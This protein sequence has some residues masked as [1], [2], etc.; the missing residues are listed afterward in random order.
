MFKTT[1]SVL[2]FATAVAGAQTVTVGSTTST[3]NGATTTITVPVMVAVPPATGT[4]GTSSMASLRVEAGASLGGAIT[5]ALGSADGFKTVAL[6]KVVTDTA[7][8]WNAATNS[9]TVPATGTY[10]IVSNIRLADFAPSGISY[11][12]GVDTANVDSFSFLWTSTAAGPRNGF[13][14]SRVMQLSAGQTVSLFAYIDSKTAIH[15]SSA[16]LNIQQL[17]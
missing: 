15:L 16:I 7:T 10:L 5:Q 1:F 14:N 13:V 9:Y 12:Q 11:G 17:Q 2:L 6:S 4:S 3:T 8:G